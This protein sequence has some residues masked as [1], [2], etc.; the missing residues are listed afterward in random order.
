MTR[1]SGRTSSLFPGILP[2]RER[3]DRE[4]KR[5][6]LFTHPYIQCT[7]FSL[8]VKKPNNGGAHRRFVV[9]EAGERKKGIPSSGAWPTESI[10]AVRERGYGWMIPS[11]QRKWRRGWWA[12]L[13]GGALVEGRRGCDWRADLPLIGNSTAQSDPLG[14]TSDLVPAPRSGC[15]SLQSLAAIPSVTVLPSRV[16]WRVDADAPPQTY[17]V[18]RGDDDAESWERGHG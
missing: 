16:V 12:G 9:S 10:S 14:C 1:I 5:D 18:M 8:A 7:D 11:G 15:V 13:V 2:I 3:L 17:G 6:W 4:T